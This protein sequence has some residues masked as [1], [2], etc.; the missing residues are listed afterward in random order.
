MHGTVPALRLLLLGALALAAQ[1]CDLLSRIPLPPPPTIDLGGL[2]PRTPDGQ[3]VLVEIAGSSVAVDLLTVD[4]ITALAQC[5]DT[6]TTCVAGGRT[7]DDCVASVSACGGG[8]E[9]A[10]CPRAC[11]DAYASARASGTRPVAAFDAVFFTQLTC[12]PE[13]AAMPGVR[14]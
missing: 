6:V 14:P 1:G 12:L 11:I 13:V 2:L 3:P 5:A 7:L 9:G 8:A 10:C 4:P